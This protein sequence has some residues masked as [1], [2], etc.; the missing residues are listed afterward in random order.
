M[1]ML[2][3]QLLQKGLLLMRSPAGGR[4]PGS[5]GA[6]AERE[7]SVCGDTQRLHIILD[8]RAQREKLDPRL[9]G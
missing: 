1:Q 2:E 6:S 4:P 9:P 8:L 3:A 7:R 5:S